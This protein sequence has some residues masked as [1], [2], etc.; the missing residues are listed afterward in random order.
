VVNIFILKIQTF[1]YMNH[2]K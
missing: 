2:I 1:L